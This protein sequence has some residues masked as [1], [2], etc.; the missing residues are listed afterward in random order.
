MD[1]WRILL[2]SCLAIKGQSS[3]G[4]YIAPVKSRPL[5]F[6]PLFSFQGKSFMPQYVQENPQG[7][8][9][10]C[11]LE[12]DLEDKMRMPVWI[13]MEDNRRLTEGLTQNVYVRLKLLRF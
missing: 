11:R 8:S 10:L 1:V 7:Y 3:P 6:S 13:K 2:M 12:L 9:P 5:S 4:V